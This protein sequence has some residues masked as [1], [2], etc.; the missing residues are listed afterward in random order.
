MANGGA[1]FRL[2]MLP[3]FLRYEYITHHQRFSVN[4]ANTEHYPE[5]LLRFRA[6]RFNVTRL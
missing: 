2:R 4:A 1:K 6:K 3:L 5:E